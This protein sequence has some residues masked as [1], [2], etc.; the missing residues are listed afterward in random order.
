MEGTS[1]LSKDTEVAHRLSQAFT[2]LHYQQEDK[3]PYIYT[4]NEIPMFGTRW[5]LFARSRMG[6]TRKHG[7]IK[8]M[9]NEAVFP[10]Q[11][12]QGGDSLSLSLRQPSVWAVL[13]HGGGKDGSTEPQIPWIHG[14]E[15]CVH[16]CTRSWNECIRTIF[17]TS[18]GICC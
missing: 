18:V 12:S 7:M 9:E 15:G 11:S 3:K 5:F 10:D 2:P 1:A 16:E 13:A 6:K 4:A 14:T 8:A 17:G